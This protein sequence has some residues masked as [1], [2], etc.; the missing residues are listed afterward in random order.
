[1]QLFKRPSAYRAEFLPPESLLRGSEIE[2]LEAVR[3]A[4]LV[5]QS[6]P[7]VGARRAPGVD[8]AQIAP[9]RFVTR[10]FKR[11][12]VD[13]AAEMPL[14]RAGVE[15]DRDAPLG[16]LGVQVGGL[17]REDDGFPRSREAANALHTPHGFDDRSSLRRVEGGD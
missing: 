4:E 1:M 3:A 9:V 5:I 11:E 16:M 17:Q 8:D 7:V 15:R 13:Q 10:L 14:E 6:V 2:V 12:V